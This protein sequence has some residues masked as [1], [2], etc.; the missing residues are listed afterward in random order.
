MD[1]SSFFPKQRGK[2]MF[3]NPSWLFLTATIFTVVLI[4]N[5]FRNFM[6]GIDDKLSRN[7]I[8]TKADVQKE[9]PN[10]FIKVTIVEVIPI[11]LIVFALT[12]TFE[13][14]VKPNQSE[15]LIPL[16]VILFVLLLGII[17]TFSAK[18]NVLSHPNINED[19]KQ[20]VNSLSYIGIALVSAIPIISIVGMFILLGL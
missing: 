10:F 8:K 12:K 18:N 19:V 14:D 11:L 2:G 20:Y 9:V 15:I 1:D 4:T 6:V 16:V 5:V 13:L 7:E 3:Y 17:M